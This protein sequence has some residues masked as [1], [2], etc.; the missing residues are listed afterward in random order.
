MIRDG[1]FRPLVFLEHAIWAAFFMAVAL[2]AAVS[3]WRQPASPNRPAAR[4]ASAIDGTP[5]AP[6]TDP[7]PAAHGALLAAGFLAGVLVAAKTLA[8]MLHAALLVPAVAFLSPRRQ[9]LLA[10]VLGGLAL[11]WPAA[12]A[13]DAVPQDFLLTRAAA[14][15]PER[16]ASLKFRFDNEVALYDR[17]M[18]KPLFGWGSWGRGQLHNPVDGTLTS[19]TDGRWIITLGNFGWV[20]FIA[21]FGLLLAPVLLLWR[22]S[23]ACGRIPPHGG[24]LALILAA[25][26]VDLIPNATLTPITWLVAATLAGQALRL[27]TGAAA[28]DTGARPRIVT[29]MPQ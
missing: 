27:R 10:L 8:P 24:A 28:R 20:G 9:L 17:A 11:A 1:G 4:L 7:A 2:V 3:L 22:A 25:N 19:V 23:R 26:M 18:E 21:E 13:L 15:D 12:R 5:P 6:R 16:A 29:V 14:I